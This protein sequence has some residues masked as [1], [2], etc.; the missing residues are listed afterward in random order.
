[1][2]S[3]FSDFLE[4][5]LDFLQLLELGFVAHGEL[6]HLL[7]DFGDLGFDLLFLFEQQEFIFR[8]V[9]PVGFGFPFLEH[10]LRARVFVP[11]LGQMRLVF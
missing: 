2:R 9:R 7:V 11:L 6:V 10:L 4:F 8:L 1:M 3:G 5:F